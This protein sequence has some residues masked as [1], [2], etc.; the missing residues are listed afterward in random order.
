M[1]PLAKRYGLTLIGGNV[2]RSPALSL[3]LT[4]AGVA[5]KPLLRSGARAGD[6]L[7]VG[8]WLGDAGANFAAQRRPMPLIEEGLVAARF[9]H[10]CIDVSDGLLQDLKHLLDASRV[11]ADVDSAS[12]PMSARLRKLPN[13][14]EL[15]LR[16]GEDYALVL[17]VPPAK[18]KGLER[19]WP[20]RVPLARIGRFTKQRTLRLDGKPISPQGFVHFQ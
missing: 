11:G 1:R 12:L 17:A 2:T 10:A 9:A 18:A 5:N 6:L 7:Y 16:G 4:L 15:A 13:A 19:A 14:L 8:G 20:R 3:T